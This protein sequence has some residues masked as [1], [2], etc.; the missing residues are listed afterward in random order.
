[1]VRMEVSSADPVWL[2]GLQGN[3]HYSLMIAAVNEV[4]TGSYSRVTE[5]ITA[6]VAPEPPTQVETLCIDAEAASI[7]WEPPRNNGGAKI[8][9][10]QVLAQPPEPFKS[11]ELA[12]PSGPEGPTS[13]QFPRLAGGVTYKVSV[14]AETLGGLSA[15]S[16]EMELTVACAPPEPPSTPPLVRGDVTPST[17]ALRWDPPLDTGGC[18]IEH[19]EVLLAASES[20]TFDPSMRP[21]KVLRTLR[22]RDCTITVDRL[23]SFGGII[24][25]YALRTPKAGADLQHGLRRCA[26]RPQHQECQ[27]HQGP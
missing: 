9:C 27:G 8:V 1:M 5:V 24:L 10:Y 21:E 26:Q 16:K 12:V 19:Y 20:G 11:V 25:R 2:C 15:P 4:G 22:C 17:V 7:C 18:C 6:P 13:A 3:T 23:E 14:C